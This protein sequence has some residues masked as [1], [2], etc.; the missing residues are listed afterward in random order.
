MKLP[1]P[2]R[3]IVPGMTAAEAREAGP[4]AAPVGAPEARP[5]PAYGGALEDD[6]AVDW[7]CLQR[8]AADCIDECGLDVSCYEACA[9]EA[10]EC[11]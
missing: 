8:T 11:F 2:S 9:P 10:L 6:A 3:P 4:V 5:R 7:D 1:I